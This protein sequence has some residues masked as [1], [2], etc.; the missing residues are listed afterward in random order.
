MAPAA[1]H[2]NFFGC[3]LVGSLNPAMKGRSYVGFTV[4][5]ARRLQQH[6]GALAAGAK[7]TKRLRPCQ[8]ILIV[9]GFPSKVQALQFEWAW[10]KPRLSRAVREV[11]TTL[12]LSDKSS[13]LPNKIRLVMAMLHLSPWCHLPLTVHFLSKE[14]HAQLGS[15]QYQCAPP[16]EQM[17]VATGTMDDLK[18]LVGATFGDDGDSDS[19][20]DSD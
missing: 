7:A 18:R 19:D 5:P 11:A 17:G 2:A 12:G 20:S 3:Y 8:M 14:H 9:H 16:P 6:N 13:S 4:N 1:P 15:R 10:Q